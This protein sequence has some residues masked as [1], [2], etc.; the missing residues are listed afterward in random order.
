MKSLFRRFRLISLDT[1][2]ET[3][4]ILLSKIFN[5]NP[6]DYFSK[7]SK[8]DTSVPKISINSESNSILSFYWSSA[9]IKVSTSSWFGYPPQPVPPPNTQP[10]ENFWFTALTSA[11]AASSAEKA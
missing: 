5:P 4:E 2:R 9:F 11:L 1:H 7:Q 6:V 8:I 3:V 10:P